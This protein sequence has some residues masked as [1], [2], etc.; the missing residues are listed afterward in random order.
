MKTICKINKRVQTGIAILV[1][2]LAILSCSNTDDNTAPVNQQEFGDIEGV[3]IDE[4]GRMYDDI[5]VELSSSG[6]LVATASTNSSAN[7]TFDDVEVGNYQVYMLNPLGTVS[8][9]NN[10]KT[11]AVTNGGEQTDFPFKSVPVDALLV[12]GDIDILDEVLNANRQKPTDPDEL[13]YTPS[14]IF[15]PNSALVPIL[16]PDAHQMTF[17]EWDDASG[18]AVVVC[19]DPTTNYKLEFTGLIPDGVYTVWNGIFNSDIGPG[20]PID[21]GT[22][23]MGVG[24]LGDGTSNILLAS[25]TG[26]AQL[27]VDALPGDLSMF[28]TMPSCV[29]TDVPAFS[30]VINYHIDGMTYG[31]NPGPDKQ[32]VAH[33]F[34][35]Y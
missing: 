26:E 32:D 18:F 20:D 6:N 7:Y 11:V 10:P 9:G 29:L 24:A 34:I 17:G 28:G 2:S 13:L 1:F 31:D 4:D 15:D 5:I 33:M 35:Y 12:A 8:I 30:L 21:F 25:S 23:F 22:D 16:A 19:D 3:V 14:D 27:E